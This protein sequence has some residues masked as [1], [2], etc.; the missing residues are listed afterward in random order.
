MQR[1]KR[2]SVIARRLQ[3]QGL[4][5][6]PFATAVDAVRWL[7]AVQ[8][9]DYRAARWALGQRTSD[10]T[11]AG[12]D[13]LFD[14]GAIVR[15]HVMRPTW[16]F[17]VA[18]D[19]R[20]LLVLTAPRVR[21]GLAGRHRQLEIDEQVAARANEVI[22]QALAGGRHATR[23]QLGEALRRAG[24]APDGQR[25]PHFLLGAELDGLIVSGPRMERQF[26]YALLDERV[27][28][29]R[30]LDRNEAVTELITR[31]FRSH[32]PAQIRDFVWWSG[33]STTDA[34][35]GIAL[36]RSALDHEVIDGSDYWFDAATA[37]MQRASRNA[38]LLPSFDEYTVGYRDRSALLDPDRPFAAEL[39]SF[40][41]ILS[42]VVTIRG[43]VRGSWRRITTRGRAC[44]QVRTLDPL[45]SSESAAV[46][47]ACRRL[48]RF[49]ERD[50][51]LTW[52]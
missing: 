49:V 29:A 48:R 25:L 35:A 44:I 38:H 31:Y 19:I 47:D 39:F 11:E 43:E 18:D 5:G 20:W 36:A 1:S 13:R 42:N 14:Q 16:H 22:T 45:R 32:G 12:V 8:S 46:E 9:Q 26:T 15:T 50:V 3:A 30:P 51:S 28:P 24:I 37:G 7:G 21:A 6:E 17:V 52:S 33:L 23:A 4:V 10:A 34:R 41:S 2:L 27:P 40:A